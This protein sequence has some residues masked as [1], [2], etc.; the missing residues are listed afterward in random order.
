MP[1]CVIPEGQKANRGWLA[2]DRGERLARCG[3]PA[4]C[5]REHRESG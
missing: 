5:R 2:K 1:Y 4:L 3:D